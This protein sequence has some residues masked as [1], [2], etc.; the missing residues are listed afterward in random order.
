MSKEN[1]LLHLD[2]EWYTP[3]PDPKPDEK[4]YSICNVINN[5]LPPVKI[6]RENLSRNINNSLFYN[7]YH[8]YPL[9]T[10]EHNASGCMKP[11]VM[12]KIWPRLKDRQD[13]W[14]G[15]KRRPIVDLTIYTR[16]RT[17]RVPGSSKWKDYHP[18]PLPSLEF[19][20]DTRMA[21]RRTQPDVLTPELS[22]QRDVNQHYDLSKNGKRLWK[23][24]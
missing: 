17:F 18:R 4:L 10:F 9:V 22:I 14:C 6:I 23:S 19:F 11:F 12:N 24:S 15:R 3:F 21:D 16:N 8:L 1:A 7:N 5:T 20:L 2:V 13:M